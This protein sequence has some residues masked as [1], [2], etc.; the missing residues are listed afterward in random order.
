MGHCDRWKI[1]QTSIN[2]P[3]WKMLAGHRHPLDKFAPKEFRN[4]FPKKIDANIPKTSF[5]KPPIYLQLEISETAYLP[6]LQLHKH[7]NCICSQRH[8]GATWESSHLKQTDHR[9]AMALWR[10]RV[11]LCLNCWQYLRPCLFTVESVKVQNGFPSEK[12]I[13]LPTGNPPNN[14]L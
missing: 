10:N 8:Q 3:S 2:M 13:D 9:R 6:R 5:M 12:W 1:L 7:S 4:H 11:N 14:I